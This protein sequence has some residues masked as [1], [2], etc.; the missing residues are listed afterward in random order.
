ML[1]I[2]RINT[3][4]YNKLTGILTNVSIIQVTSSW[5]ITIKMNIEENCFLTD[6][7]LKLFYDDNEEINYRDNLNF[8]ATI[9]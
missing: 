2:N 4:L 5:K 8:M 6:N 9:I 1:Y 3:I 7:R